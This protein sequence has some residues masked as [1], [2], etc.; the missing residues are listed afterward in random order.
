[1]SKIDKWFASDRNFET[2]IQLL[3]ELGFKDRQILAN[4][5]NPAKPISQRQEKLEW[6]LLRRAGLPESVLFPAS[7]QPSAKDEHAAAPPSAGS[8]QS[9]MAQFVDNP[10]FDVSQL[11]E[12]LRDKF[13]R[14]KTIYREMD[15]AHTAAKNAESD[16][17]RMEKI[18]L[19]KSLENEQLAYWRELDAWANEN[20]ALKAH[21]PSLTIEEAKKRRR[22]VKGNITRAEKELGLLKG[23]KLKNRKASIKEWA[24]ELQTLDAQIDGVTV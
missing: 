14:I 15:D 18:N 6:C 16:E 10:V 17:T 9:K 1:M 3:K 4:L 5:E 2:G 11:P 20:G 19:V 21:T 13:L 24:E 8:L 7:A 12:E 23:A 22:I